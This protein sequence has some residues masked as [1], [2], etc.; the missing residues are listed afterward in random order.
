MLVDTQLPAVAGSCLVHPAI[1]KL[2][3]PPYRV[4]YT[5]HLDQATLV[6]WT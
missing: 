5:Y 4:A 3:S 1:G 6:G 2:L